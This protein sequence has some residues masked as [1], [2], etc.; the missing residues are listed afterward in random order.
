MTDSIAT[1]FIIASVD[2]K[3]L[4]D[5][6]AFVGN[7]RVSQGLTSDHFLIIYRESFKIQIYKHSVDRSFC[8]K[9]SESCSICFQKEPNSNPLLVLQEWCKEI[10]LYGCM[11]SELPR[12]E[13]FGAEAW[14]LDPEG[15]R[16]ALFVPRKN[17]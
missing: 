2:P 14:F 16:F 11:V 7:G 12:L 4:A 10:S 6:Y 3:A 9:G 5:F 1:S 17:K 13:S 15:N 8:F